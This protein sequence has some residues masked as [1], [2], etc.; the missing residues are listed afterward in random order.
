MAPLK[1]EREKKRETSTFYA[2]LNK[3]LKVAGKDEEEKK[4]PSTKCLAV[5]SSILNEQPI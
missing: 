4:D 3:Q 5:F 2:T 1:R